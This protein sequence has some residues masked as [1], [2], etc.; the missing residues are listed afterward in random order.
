MTT[1]NGKTMRVACVQMRSGT[2][3]AANIAVM[4]DFVRQAA[5]QG[6]TYV[7][8][9]EMTG[10]VQRQRE[11]LFAAIS[12]DR[13]NPVFARAGALAGEHGIWLH[14]GSTAV[15]AGNGKAHNRAALFA[16]SGERIAVYDKIHM[17]D[18]DLD[19]G[20]S[21]R[22]SAVY[23]PG[24]AAVVT[25]LDDA[26]LGLAICYD[27]RFPDLFRREAVAGAS[28]LTAP[29]AF[30]R[31]TGEAH[32]HTL[33]RARAIEN[34]AFMICAAQG[35]LH[36]DGRETFGHSLVVDPWGRI[37]GELD[38]DEPGVLVCDIDLAASAT[39]RG[40]IPNLKN[41]R[42]FDLLVEGGPETALAGKG[43]A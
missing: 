12:P 40:R 33:I 32:W 29:A 34:G 28:I 10:L 6:A 11:P 13:D 27:L 9:P 22:E 30:T 3:E 2:D 39:A 31:Q 15:D 4:D 25:G 8:T 26:L 20:E 14:V 7:Q 16:P 36:E 35:G 43:A 42:Q 41:A 19:H 24:R 17:F 21:W 18:V 1:V 5:A 23:E 37:V 38:H